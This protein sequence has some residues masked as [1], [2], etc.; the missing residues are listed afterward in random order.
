MI[1]IDYNEFWSSCNTGYPSIVRYGLE[2]E[3]ANIRR[4]LFAQMMG[5]A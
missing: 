4:Q 3:T 2:D 5:W 1:E